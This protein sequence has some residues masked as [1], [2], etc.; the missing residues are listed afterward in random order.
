L[1]TKE[2]FVTESKKFKQEIVKFGVPGREIITG[3]IQDFI[4][5][6]TRN[7]ASQFV[8]TNRS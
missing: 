3:S 8:V 1:I 2:N 6:G 4:V 7:R 5:F